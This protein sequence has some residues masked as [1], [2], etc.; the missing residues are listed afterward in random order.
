MIEY[1]HH[2]IFMSQNE[3]CDNYVNRM[4]NGPNNFRWPMKRNII[5][6][7]NMIYIPTYKLEKID[8]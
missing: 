1:H 6:P 5:L 2:H 8:L 3:S 7:N 4:V